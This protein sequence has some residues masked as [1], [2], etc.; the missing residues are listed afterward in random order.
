MRKMANNYLVKDANGNYFVGWG[1]L[2]EPVMKFNNNKELANR[3]SYPI[4]QRTAEKMPSLVGFLGT[5]EKANIETKVS[6]EIEK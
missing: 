5:V 3:M 2:G 4:A 1:H 6:E